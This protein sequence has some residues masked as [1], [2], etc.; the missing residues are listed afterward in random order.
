M[1]NSFSEHLRPDLTE[2]RNGL[3]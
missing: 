3:Q 1:R 2:Y